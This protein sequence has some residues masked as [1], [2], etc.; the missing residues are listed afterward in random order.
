M[1]RQATDRGMEIRRIAQAEAVQDAG[2][3]FDAAIRS[4]ATERFLADERH[5]LLIAYADGVPAGDGHRR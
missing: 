4:E 5:H 3:L 1:P 2:H